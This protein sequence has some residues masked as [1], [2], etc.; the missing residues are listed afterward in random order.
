MTRFAGSIG[1]P[2][3]AIQNRL[4]R[5]EIN[6]SVPVVP[7]N[8][9]KTNTPYRWAEAHP[10]FVQNRKRTKKP[11][12]GCPWALNLLE[13]K[14]RMG[15]LL[16]LLLEQGEYLLGKLVGLAQH[17]VGCLHEDLVLGELGHLC[18]HVDVADTA[19]GRGEVGAGS[20][21]VVDCM[22]QAVLVGT[23]GC[24]LAGYLV[25]STVDNGNGAGS[26][27]LVCHQ[28]IVHAKCCG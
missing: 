9:V 19:F 20:T 3:S 21:Q 12:G 18:C 4:T 26:A 22:L 5:W 14:D 25:D 10:T 2:K 15:F 13:C 16:L 24:P 27:L 8:N 7:I 23:Q 28:D 6:P 17:G 11:G 1:N